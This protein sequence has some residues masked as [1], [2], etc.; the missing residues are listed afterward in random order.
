MSYNEEIAKTQQQEYAELY[1]FIVGNVTTYYTSY[2]VDVVFQGNTYLARPI[3]RSNFTFSERIRS[4]VKVNISA[5][6]EDAIAKF[7]ANTP[8]IPIRVKI[9]RVFLTTDDNIILFDGEVVDVTISK[10]VGT[11][12]VEN[13]TE[14]SQKIPK[15]IFQSRCNNSLFDSVC[16]VDRA[17]RE[18]LAIVTVDNSDLVS[19]TFA[20]YPDNYFTMGHTQKS[21]DIRLITNH[22]GDRITLQIPFP[23]STLETGDQIS[24]WPGCKKDAETCITKF[25]NFENFVGFP[26]IPNSNPTIF[27]F[28]E[29]K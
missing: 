1:E 7:I 21:D 19:S 27:G 18:V 6:V 3:K 25:N 24:A 11:I 12:V 4:T 26:Y 28:I 29:S 17:E 5:P 10:N 22:V 13:N 9:L 16:K 14:L 15:M 20:L 2:N 23:Q 8:A